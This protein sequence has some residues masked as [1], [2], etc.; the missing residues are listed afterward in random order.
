VVLAFPCN[1]FGGQEPGAA[2]EI[3]AF[4]D[5]KGATF[6]LFAKLDVNGFNTHP[7]FKDLKAQQGEFLSSDVKWNFAKFLVDRDG[8]CVGRYGP[9][10]PPSEIESDV[11]KLLD[12]APRFDGKVVPTQG[13]REP[14]LVE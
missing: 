4:A 14:A 6:P 11:V 12:A 7:L 10:V 5:A 8:T 2:A 3:R 13:V 9:Q 1:Q